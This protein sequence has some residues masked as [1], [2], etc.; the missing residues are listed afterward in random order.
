MSDRAASALPGFSDADE[1]A[2]LYDSA[3]IGLCVLDRELRYVRVNERLA[4]MNGISARDHIGRTL[5]EVLPDLGDQAESVMRRVLGGQA[6]YG[7][8]FTGS[9]PAVPGVGRTWGV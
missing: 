7:I 6:F 2:A 8:E 5:R 3:P 4:E 9:T 1:I